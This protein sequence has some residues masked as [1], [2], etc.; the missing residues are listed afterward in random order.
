MAKIKAKE[1]CDIGWHEELRDILK[2]KE[3]RKSISFRNCSFYNYALSI[4]IIFNFTL[5]HGFEILIYS[6]VVLS[7]FIHAYKLSYSNVFHV[8]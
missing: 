8:I 4:Y 5:T 2:E 6:C 3:W 1:L 7:I